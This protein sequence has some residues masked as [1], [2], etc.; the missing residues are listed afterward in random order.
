MGCIRL[1]FL[2]PAVTDSRELILSRNN[3]M[4]ILQNLKSLLGMSIQIRLTRLMKKTRVKKSHRRVPLKYEI[5]CTK[6]DA[7]FR[8]IEVT[9]V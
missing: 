8:G 6:K 3:S 1:N 4:K 2:L 5:L 9:S 7:E